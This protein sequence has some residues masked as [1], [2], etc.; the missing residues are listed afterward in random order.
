MNSLIIICG[1][2]KSGTSLLRNLLDDHSEIFC[3]PIETHF[4]QL[5]NYYINN[6]FRKSIPK[7]SNL[8][9]LKLNLNNW[10]KHYND[11]ENPYAD[12]IVKNFFDLQLF[13]N[14]IESLNEN[15]SLNEKI[16]TYFNSIRNSLNT[17]IKS[18]TYLL[19]KST[20]NAEVALHYKK[21]FPTAKFIHI[22]R[23]PYSNMVALRKFKTLDNKYPY[24]QKIIQVF[25]NNLYHL[26]HNVE[27]IGNDYYVLRYE[28]L[29][30]HPREEMEKLCAFLSIEFEDILLQPTMLGK[31]WGGNSTTGKVF[32]TIDA[33]GL[34]KW[35]KEIHPLEVYYLNKKF[36]FF[37]R[38]YK[39]EMKEIKGT[40]FK[41]CPHED[42][43]HYFHN[44][45]LNFY[46]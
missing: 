15:S 12:S 45:L 37:F 21:H 10:L 41:P 27:L 22:V 4:F 44:R 36:P 8:N 29:L 28:D 14:E 11:L 38:D 26:Y 33:S 5:S 43:K 42:I 31:P 20:E 13:N 46:L 19:E 23:N 7:K 2:H 35:E 17:K 3:I 30:Q 24:L 25:E 34:N 18:K 32:S 39:Y 40:I 9:D 16:N 1:I 6:E